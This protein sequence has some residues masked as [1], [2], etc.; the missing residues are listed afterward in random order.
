MA[1]P[2]RGKVSPRARRLLRAILPIGLILLAL[3]IA[4][5][6]WGIV[7]AETFGISVASTVLGLINAVILVVTGIIYRRELPPE[8]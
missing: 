7:T 8:K 2:A 4:R 6:V 3:W 5:I 1:D